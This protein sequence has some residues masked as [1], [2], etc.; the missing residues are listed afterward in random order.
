[1]EELMPSKCGA[2]KDSWDSMDSKEIKPIKPKVYQSSIFIGRT[3]VEAEA[4]V[5]W[6]PNAN[7]QLIGKDP[8]AGKDWEQEE[9]GET[10][11]EMVGWHHHVHDSMD[12]NLSKPWEIVRDRE[13]WC[14]AVHK[15]TKSWTWLSDWTTT[16]L[17]RQGWLLV[18]SPNLPSLFSFIEA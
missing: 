4:L 15:V 1:M 7:I 10:E 6:P 2:G 3:D 8:G 5:L 11:D 18:L 13:G 17:L 12:M 14:A 16:T 9:K